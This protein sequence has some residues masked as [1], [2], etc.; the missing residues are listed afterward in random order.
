MI[1]PEF[2][3]TSNAK[4]FEY[5]EEHIYFNNYETPEIRNFLEPF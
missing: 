2:V 5:A 1:S 4:N 3:D